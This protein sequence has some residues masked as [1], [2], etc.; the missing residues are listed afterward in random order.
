MIKVSYKTRRILS[1]LILLVGLPF[2]VGLV[3]TLMSLLG[4]V[5]V[6]LELL[7]YVIFG[8]AWTYP[9]KFIFS[10]VGQSDDSD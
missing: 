7:L 4:E 10:G 5:H 1:L 3:V 8:I 9:T 2:Y 6:L